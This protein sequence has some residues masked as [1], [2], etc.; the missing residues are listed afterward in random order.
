M[1]T[2][3]LGSTGL[4]IPEIVL[5]GGQVGG[6]LIDADDEAKLTALRY[7]LDAGIN[8]IDTAPQYGAGKSE[9]SLGRLLREVDAE[10]RIST[11]LRLDAADR[12]DVA[13][14]VEASLAA[15]LERLDRSRVDLLQLHNRIGDAPGMLPADFVMGPVAEALA[16]M[17]DAGGTSHIGLTAL[18]HAPAC[19]AVIASGAFETAQIY[20]NALNPSAARPMPTGWRGQDFGGLIDAARG[21]GMGILA[22]RVFAAGALA[23][24]GAAMVDSVI[25]EDSAAESEKA[26]A[27]SFLAALEPEDRGSPAGAALRFV[28]AN[29]DISCAVVGVAQIDHIEDAVRAADAGPLTSAGMAGLE[30]LYETGFG[31]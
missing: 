20:Y 13:G 25:A 30:A 8:W 5:G 7:A 19:R 9:A 6:L 28:L 31:F 16:A 14:A 22:I 10:P 1:R 15:S 18:G 27:R 21:K 17:R 12:G 3:L 29:R 26:R 4:E 24:G 2:R 11:K 23:T